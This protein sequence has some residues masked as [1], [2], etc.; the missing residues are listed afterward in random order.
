[1]KM[2]VP[3]M[4][5]VVICHNGESTLAATLDSLMAQTYP[6]KYY[7]VIVVDDASTDGTATVVKRYPRVRYVGL[8]KNVG[9]SGARNAGLK[10]AKGDIY[11]AFD[12]D[13]IAQKNWLHELVKGYADKNVVGVGG[14]LEESHAASGFVGQYIAACDS[15]VGLQRAS[16]T[17]ESAHGP[18]AR[19]WRYLK[20]Q[21]RK[22]DTAAQA[23]KV[24]VQELYG[25]NGSFPIRVLKKV[26][27]W[28]L[29]RSGIEDRDLSR[30]IRLAYPGRPF[31]LM[32]KAVITHDRGQTLAQYLL[33]P[34]K[35][36][37]KNV[38]FYRDAHMLPPLFPF[39]VLW[40]LLA[41]G[42]S[43]YSRAAGTGAALLLPMVF[44]WGWIQY[45]F[46]RRNPRAILFPYI[47]LAEETS[48]L[49]GIV[50]GYMQL[51][52]GR[53]GGAVRGGIHLLLTTVLLAGW[54]T[55][56]LYTPSVW[57][58]TCIS[59]A[60]LLLVPGYCLWQFI[61][62]KNPYGS[63]RMRPFAYTVG[64]SLLFL[65]LVGLGLNE[66]Y[67]LF[68]L[69]HPFLARPLTYTVMASTWVVALAAYIR[70]PRTYRS[71]PRLH[72]AVKHLPSALGLAM[73][74]L[75]IP[76]LAVAGAVTLNNGGSGKLALLA[77]AASLLLTVLMLFYRRLL[78]PFYAWFLYVICLGI[79]LGTS[80]RGWNITGH[81]VMQEF[82]VFQLT[83]QHA[84]WHMQ[85]YQDAYTACLSITILPTIFQK[86]TGIGSPYVYKIL[87][88]LFS[89]L[90]AP[91]IYTLYRDFVGSRKSLLAVLVCIT[92]PTFL[93]DIMMLNRQETALLFF[94]I[95]LLVG[96]DKQL[97]PR[98]KSV[99]GFLLLAGMVF[100]HYSTSYVALGALL[101]GLGISILWYGGQRFILR[102]RGVSFRKLTS[103]YQAPVIIAAAFLLIAWGTFV[104][105]TSNNISQTIQAVVTA[106][107]QMATHTVPVAAQSQP[108]SATHY[109]A[110]AVQSRSLPAQDYYPSQVVAQYPLQQTSEIVTPARS[111]VQRL[112][113]SASSLSSLYNFIRTGYGIA[114]EGLVVVGLFVVLSYRR[115]FQRI[116]LQYIFLGFGG[117]VLI[118]TQVILP[119][120]TINYG[121][122]RLLQEMLI[123]F[124]VPMVSTC[125]L[126]MK[127]VRIPAAVAESLL[128]LVIVG[129]FAVLSGWLP[130]ITGGFKATLPLANQ[131]FYYQAYYTH[132]EEVSAAAWLD[133]HT[134][135]GSRVYSDEFMRRK[136]ITYANI[137]AQPT[138]VPGALPIDS[139][140]FLDY[141]NTLSGQAP[142][143]DGS[144][145]I[146]YQPPTGFLQTVKNTVY[147]SGNVTIY[148]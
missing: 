119:P 13:C 82:Q 16:D 132:Q 8:A 17:G 21:G 147:S 121:P 88:Q 78:E 47:Q 61:R 53:M 25:A 51:A 97:G 86:L 9:V 72:I 49:L 14:R 122:T 22:G 64:L 73:V 148:K 70:S 98:V 76:L 114:I 75:S 103:L 68:G 105:Q 142:A 125:V 24:Q 50:R 5:V 32:P 141:G 26:G 93:T 83:L 80:M 96:M 140:V 77:V 31:V 65:M 134:P 143:Y 94:V 62:G 7:E 81:D 28:R 115:R 106:A 137:F 130:T 123:V 124:A 127:A 55:L 1:M 6:R 107:R 41:A 128:S 74:G 52:S 36:G 35:R 20:S 39:P 145:V 129:S 11:V 38:L 56:V 87:F 44:Y 109:A 79:L 60:F 104:T 110:A 108:S 40:L 102:R 48:V 58:H 23:E 112:G 54:G 66:F 34:Y 42:L 139:Y 135:A 116:P 99:L 57:W 71:V 131:G 84:A 29:E 12:D 46:S 85:Y 92:F 144:K 146:Y 89:A 111:W 67:T 4:S 101:V 37:P 90:L 126:L 69:T 3:F 19:L 27:G 91:L 30:R 136:L 113:V 33:R 15:D 100:S 120:P 118:M 138:L 2:H 45:A 59:F 63:G 117:L 18:L 43:V 95:S 133:G 10:V